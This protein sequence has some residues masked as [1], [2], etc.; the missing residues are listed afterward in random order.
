MLVSVYV[1]TGLAEGCV[2]SPDSPK[3]AGVLTMC[4]DWVGRLC[5]L[6]IVLPLGRAVKCVLIGSSHV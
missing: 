1:H 3:I 5:D 2:L 6:G 4:L